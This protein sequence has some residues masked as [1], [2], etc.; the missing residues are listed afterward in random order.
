MSPTKALQS[1]VFLFYVALAAGLLLFAGV[2][3]GVLKWAFRK[4]VRHAWTAYR[5][6]LFMMPVLLLV[7]FLGREAAIG[8]VTVL[9]ILAFRE[10]AGA[11]GLCHD[12]A[13]TRAV[14]LGIIALGAVCLL[15]DPIDGSAGWYGLFMATP[16]FVVAVI[17]AIPVVRNRVAGPAPAA[18]PRYYGVRVF[19]LDVRPPG[20]PGQ[21]C[22]C[23]QL[24]G[25]PRARSR[26]ERC[27]G[28]PLRQAVRPAPA[29]EQHQ[30]AKDLGRRHSVRLVLSSMLPWALHFTFAHFNATDCILAGL[31]VGVGGQLGDLVVSVIKRDLGIKDM[32]TL[33][34][35]HGGI[36]DRFDS[37]IYVAPLFFH[38]VRFR[39]N[40]GASP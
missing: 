27:G 20:V 7:F 13:I 4:N 1:P 39:H 38:F 2:V 31:M 40:F 15:S 8:F 23:L 16:V 10:F 11:T 9:A 34:A 29:Q 21:L 17:V 33:I 26:A 12:R 25:L 18:G 35:G 5:G 36:L 14:Y 37:L 32:G 19:R 30:P 22:L 3:L 6:W 28:I 24:P